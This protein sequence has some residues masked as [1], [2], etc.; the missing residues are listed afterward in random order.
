M[1]NPGGYAIIVDPM[2]LRGSQELDTF[3]CV[4][5]NGVVFLRAQQAPADAGGWCLCCMKPV[6]PRCAGKECRPFMRWVEEQEARGRFLRSA[7]LG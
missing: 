7:G 6:C 3:T 1:R 4:H 5:C 2:T